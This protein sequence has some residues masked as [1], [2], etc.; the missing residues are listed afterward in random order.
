LLR[1]EETTI[2]CVIPFKGCEKEDEQGK[3]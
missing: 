2:K 3:A 1:E